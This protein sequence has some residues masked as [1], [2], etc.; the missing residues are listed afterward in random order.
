[1]TYTIDK[2]VTQPTD[3]RIIGLIDKSS[4]LNGL[5]SLLV[6]QVESD[7]SNLGHQKTESILECLKLA[8]VTNSQIIDG[9]DTLER[10]E[11]VAQIN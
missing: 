8:L 10:S 6:N 2:S 7:F 3:K 5:L 4:H 9:L 1:M 11:I